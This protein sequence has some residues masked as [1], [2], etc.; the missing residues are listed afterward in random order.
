MS[1]SSPTKVPIYGNL[2]HMYSMTLKV[3][4]T[5]ENCTYTHTTIVSGKNLLLHKHT[6]DVCMLYVMYVCM[7][8]CVCVV[9]YVCVY[10]CVLY[11]MYVCMCVCC[12]LCMCVC[13]CDVCAIFCK[14]WGVGHLHNPIKTYTVGEKQAQVHIL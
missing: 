14:K 3:T 4:R 8:V 11:V 2:T 12:M 9:C 10:V 1:H 7:C 13:V 6:K 5:T